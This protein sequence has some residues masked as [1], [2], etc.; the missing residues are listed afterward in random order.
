MTFFP[1]YGGEKRINTSFV[2][3]KKFYQHFLKYLLI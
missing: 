3:E 1:A 2:S